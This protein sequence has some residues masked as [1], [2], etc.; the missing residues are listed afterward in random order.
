MSRSRYA[1]IVATLGPAT[2]T[3]AR[4][5]A[6]IEAGVDVFRLNFSHGERAQHGQLIELVRSA[7]D[8]IGR[9]V[10]IL[11]DLQ[12][13]KIRTGRLEQGPVELAT[14]STVVL[15]T[16]DL[17]G[18][19]RRISTT[20]AG[21]PRDVAPGDTILLDDGRIR[22]RVAAS[23]DDEVE[24]VVE[25]GGRL[26]EHKGIN[27]P[28]V[29]VS[30]PALTEKDREDLAFGVERGVDFIAL[31]F[32]REAAEVHQ[33]REFIEKRLQARLPIVSKLEK[34]E[35]IE[36]L[37]AILEASDA[38]MVARGDLG[39]ELPPERVPMIQKDVI[40]KA[41][42][43]GKPVIT[44]TQMLESMVSQ[45][46]PTRAEASDVANAVWDGTDAV[47]LSAES[48]IGQYPV[49]AVQVMDRIV[50]EAEKQLPRAELQ[51]GS[52]THAHAISR[53]ARSLAEDLDVRAI[54]GFTRTGRTACLLS[55]ERPSVPILAFTSEPRLARRLAL[56]WGVTPFVCSAAENLDALVLQLE[57]LVLDAGLVGR[58]EAVVIVGALPFRAGVH[59]N[60][61]KL[62]HVG[63]S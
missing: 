43:L 22:L 34:P 57:Q 12:G 7:A 13:P 25:H 16:R 48:A 8:R 30:T 4:I 42:R 5:E 40:H 55:Q 26:S 44:A 17:A 37:D 29:R 46:S 49:E 3:A 19:A 51:V 39:V 6:L 38:V 50:A 47:M 11:Q 10:A 28:G 33:A 23:R 45:P 56:W 24:T 31:S 15:T 63:A 60:F 27:L 35:A 14:D 32:V 9:P 52:I 20:Y 53:A 59:T 41:N 1:K 62:H 54:V 58:G 18:N 36:N 21:L 2:A 61:L